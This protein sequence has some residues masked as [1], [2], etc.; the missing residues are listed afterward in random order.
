MTPKI[1]NGVLSA[2]IISSVVK[3]G[4]F[5]YLYLFFTGF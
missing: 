1:P 4:Q 2:P 3:G 5:D